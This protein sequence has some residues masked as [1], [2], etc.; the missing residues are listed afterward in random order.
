MIFGLIVAA[1]KQSRFDSST[2]KA[3][4]PFCDGT[5]LDHNIKT[6]KKCCSKVYIITSLE[7]DDK[8]VNYGNRI[9][10][11]SGFGTGDAIY[12]ALGIINPSKNDFCYIIWGDSILSERTLDEL[13]SQVLYKSKEIINIAC[14][15][16]DHPYTGFGIINNECVVRFSKYGEDTT[17]LY[18]DLSLFCGNARYILD[19]LIEF[20]SKIF[21]GLNY[22]HR[23]G[24]EMEFL[25]IFND[26][27]AIFNL[28]LCTGNQASFNT[29]EEYQKIYQELVGCQT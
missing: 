9:P 19:K 7:N 15:K 2:P 10:I 17:G 29:L 20:R 6:L 14:E 26:V 23:H 25:D 1:G 12:K 3:L 22:H 5:V 11:E 13:N 27:D 21:D 8:F 4:M 16:D 24:D 28:V 18:H